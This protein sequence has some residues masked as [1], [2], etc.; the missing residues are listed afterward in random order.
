MY[1]LIKN[2]LD[3]SSVRKNIISNNL[4]NVNTKNFK[5]SDVQFEK[6][7]KSNINNTTMKVTHEKHNL[8]QTSNYRIFTEKNTSIRMDGNNVDIDM[9]KANQAAN[10]L[11]YN[12]LIS[13]IN[14]E[15]ESLASVIR[16][17]R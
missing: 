12:S 8:G 14:Y 9:E 4:A 7:L 6:Y 15:Y 16:G 2:A 10:T 13:G 3:V 1:D 11:M 17:N 5:R